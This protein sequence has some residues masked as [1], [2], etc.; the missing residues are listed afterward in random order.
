VAWNYQ[1][2]AVR[3]ESLQDEMQVGSIYVRYFLEAGDAFL[4]SLENPSHL[5]LFEKLFRRMLSNVESNPSVAILC[6]QCI[7]RLYSVCRDIIGS[8]DDM[9]L[10]VRM[11]EKAANMELQHCMIDLLEVLCLSPA[12]VLQ[13][14]DKEFVNIIIKYATLA[15]INPDQIGNVLARATANV[16]LLKDASDVMSEA[17]TMP[18]SNSP[19]T[20]SSSSSSSTSGNA[21]ATI[22]LSATEG[23]SEEEFQ[24]KLQADLGDVEKAAKIK[25]YRDS[26]TDLFVLN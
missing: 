23:Q 24:L 3:Y 20:S 10:I 25:R 13:L 18:P 16:L 5:V 12:N 9:L 8:F 7:C 21:S 22:P 2:F 1:Q 6:T 11:L 26:F 19:P 17:E 15:H 14:L 4:R